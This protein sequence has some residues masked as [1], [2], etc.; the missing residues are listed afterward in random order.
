VTEKE[1]SRI[2]TSL[3]ITLPKAY[4]DLILERGDA[5]KESGGFDGDCP[6]FSLDAKEVISFN[7]AERPK[8]SG[9]GYAFPK[10]WS[11][12]FLIG[13]NGGG[14]YYCLRL[15][16]EPGVWMIGSD[17]GNTPTFVAASLEGFVLE[18]LEEHQKEQKREAARQ[19]EYEEENA[20]E[21]KAIADS[22]D[23]K[24]R[25]W[26]EA[27]SPYAMFPALD[28]IGQRVSPRKLRLYGIA[29]CRRIENLESDDELVQA[30]A[31]AEAMVGNSPK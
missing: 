18:Q 16:D 27:R 12:F 1:L 14:D 15:D 31:L 10:W 6:A 9:T 24:A 26:L 8:N 23:P 3:E 19:E 21:L 2:E 13:T 28:N 22:G 5:L 25:Q 11:T 7:K 4:R 17:C 20:E 29:C 30:V